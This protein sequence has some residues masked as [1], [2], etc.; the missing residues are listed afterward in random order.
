[1]QRLWPHAVHAALLI[2]AIVCVARPGHA[3]RLHDIVEIQGAQPNILK[4][5]G[6]VVGLA[7]T[8]D[9]AEAAVVAQERLLERM[10]IE[11]EERDSLSAENAAIVMVTA[12]LPA[13]IKQGSRVDVKVDS[14]HD[15]ESLEGG[16]LLETH[17]RGPGTSETVYAVAQGPVSVG[18]FNAAGGGANVQQNHVAAGRIPMGATIEREV[19]S[20]ITDG[21]RIIL[22]LNNPDFTTA[23]RIQQAIN[24]AYAPEA[25]VALAAGTVRVTIPE[26]ERR[27]LVRF[28]A[29]LQDIEVETGSPANVVINERT[30]TIV[31]G[32]EVMIKPCQVAHGNLTIRVAE[33][34]IIEQPLPF[35][36]AE[37]VETEVTDVDVETTEAHLMPVEGTSAADVAEALNRLKV[38]PRDMISIFQ[39]LREVGALEAD[40]ELM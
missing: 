1:M 38:T 19:P 36:D 30:G 16:T 8:G 25:A 24:E 17:L 12:V 21:E 35:T 39:A 40:L 34:P 3:A 18:G 22:T 27:N 32:G 13:F 28:I 29:R 5:V 33:T 14:L 9:S 6:I 31:V 15:A 26:Q 4:G 7:G 23:D 37:A 10:G 20:T 11:I 2:T